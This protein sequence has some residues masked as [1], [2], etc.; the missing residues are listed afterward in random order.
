[1]AFHSIVLV[2][3]V[4]DTTEVTAKAMRKDGTLNRSALPSTF[5]HD[6]LHALEMAL[7]VRDNAIRP[8]VAPA[9]V[10]ARHPASGNR[11]ASGRDRSYAATRNGHSAERPPSISGN[12]LCNSSRRQFRT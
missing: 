7:Q 4:P 5:N 12:T 8:S 11:G 10:L 6:D 2:K 3:Q 9:G 1:M